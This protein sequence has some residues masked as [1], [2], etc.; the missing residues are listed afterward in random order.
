M[1]KLA[2]IKT[3][4]GTL[5]IPESVL[6]LYFP[7][8]VIERGIARGKSLKRAERV[9]QWKDKGRVVDLSR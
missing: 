8:E 3:S 2:E 9:K 7:A 1:D 4:K 5:L 6:R